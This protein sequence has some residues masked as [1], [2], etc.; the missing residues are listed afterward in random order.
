MSV[1]S[2]LQ[3]YL[4]ILLSDGITIN[5][6]NQDWSSQIIEPIVFWFEMV[7]S[8]RRASDETIVFKI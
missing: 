7:L 4:D 2:T 3:A 1:E 8:A 5:L 6:P